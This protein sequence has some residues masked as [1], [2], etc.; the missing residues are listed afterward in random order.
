MEHAFDDAGMPRRPSEAPFEYLGRALRGVR[1]SPPAAGRLAALFE[2]ARFS[3]HVVD[4]A[5]KEDAIGALREIERQLRAAVIVS[6]TAVHALS[7]VGARCGG[8]RR[9]RAR[10]ARRP[11]TSR[12]ISSWWP[13]WWWRASC[14]GSRRR[15]REPSPCRSSSR[16]GRSGSVSS[17]RSLARSISPRRP[18]STSTTCL[19]PIVREIAAA[20]LAR[21]GVSLDRQPERARALLGAQ[22]WELVRPDREA[23]AGG[24]AAAAAA[25]TSCVRS[26]TR[27]R[28]SRWRSRPR[29]GGPR[30]RDPRRGRA[31][32]DR[33]APSDRARPDGPARRR[34]RPDRGLPGARQ[35]AHRAVRRSASAR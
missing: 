11:L 6:R 32:R 33:Q 27:W 31:R 29:G 1:V 18:P 13:P 30:G 3:R 21:H 15:S 24:P 22:T 12:S 20:R 26:S 9:G 2:R 28:R 8:A 7:L 4:A 16:P 17:N 35:D 19:R 5:T 23:P 34:A 25:G 14:S 10:L